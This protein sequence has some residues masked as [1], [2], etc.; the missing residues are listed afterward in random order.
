MER[1]QVYKD[2]FKGLGIIKYL[3]HDGG[4]HPYRYG[5]VAVG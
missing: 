4:R 5:R 2:L 3:C 1:L